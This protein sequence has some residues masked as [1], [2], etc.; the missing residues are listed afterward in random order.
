MSKDIYTKQWIIDNAI[1]VCSRYAN[2]IL[3]L[4]ALHYQLVGLG[5]T[6][7]VQHYKR[8]VVAMIDARWEV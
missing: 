8:V 6:N 5:M 3:T 1:N 2:G 4:R 7:D